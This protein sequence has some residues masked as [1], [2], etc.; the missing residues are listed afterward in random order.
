[1][2]NYP[3]SAVSTL[4]RDVSDH[5][6]CL[7]SVSTDIP[8]TNIFRFEN[9]WILHEDFM[10]V[11]QYGWSIPVSS[12]DKEKLLGAKFKNL[13]RVLRSWQSNLSNLAATL[14]NNKLVLFLLD[15]MEEFRDLTLEEWNF[16][17]LVHQH[18]E[19]LVER[20]RIYWKQRG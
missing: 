7:I 5:S 19:S 15:S 8:K 11:L 1:M 12:Q 10:G 16:R 14:S 9:H 20:Q 18:L 3:G 17:N 13:R 6:P 2:A 4:S